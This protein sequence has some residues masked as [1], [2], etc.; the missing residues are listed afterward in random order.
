MTVVW[1][2]CLI[3]VSLFAH[4][5]LGNCMKGIRYTGNSIKAVANVR[6]VKACDI[7]CQF[8]A[9]CSY[10]TLDASSFKCTLFKVVEKKVSQMFRIS[11]LQG[12]SKSSSGKWNL[13]TWY[14][15][16]STA[17]AGSSL[18]LLEPHIITGL[19]VAISNRVGRYWRK[20][21][22]SND[23]D[24]VFLDGESKSA[25][26]RFLVEKSLRWFNLST[27]GSRKVLDDV[28]KRRE[29][30]YERTGTFPY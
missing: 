24:M 5:I 27:W 20:S 28:S 8:D 7:E 19:G 29:D 16:L 15:N 1:S 6:T 12:C 11:G 9:R 2:C 22:S 13:Q 14:W 3:P 18:A 23:K 4:Y 26:T 21:D 25:F 17:T 30:C 10:F